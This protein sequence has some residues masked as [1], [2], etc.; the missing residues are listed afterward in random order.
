MNQPIVPERRT[1]TVRVRAREILEPENERVPEEYREIYRYF[2][3]LRGDLQKLGLRE[4]YLSANLDAVLTA[5]IEKKISAN[6]IIN[7]FK[8]KLSTLQDIVD[9]QIIS[10]ERDYARNLLLLANSY[11]EKLTIE[12]DT[13]KLRAKIMGKKIVSLENLDVSMNPKLR[14][15]YTNLVKIKTAL[16][17]YCIA[18]TKGNINDLIDPLL[19]KIL[20]LTASQDTNYEKIFSQVFDQYLQVILKKET[21]FRSEYSQKLAVSTIMLN[22]GN[23]CTIGLIDPKFQRPAE[24]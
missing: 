15:L 1:D 20:D 21:Y 13:K 10:A 4:F 14:A 9:S 17:N 5:I 18:E 22:W 8:E 19:I 12:D 16:G 11:L 3:K 6:E 24:R 7:L 2:H 23:I